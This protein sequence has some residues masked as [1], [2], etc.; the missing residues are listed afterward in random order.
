M[1]AEAVVASSYGNEAGLRMTPD[2][3]AIPPPPSPKPFLEMHTERSVSPSPR[4]LSATRTVTAMSERTDLPCGCAWMKAALA[5]VSWWQV[6]ACPRH[7][8]NMLPLDGN[9]PPEPVS[10]GPEYDP[11]WQVADE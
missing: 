3:C 10:R 2:E 1:A 5:P 9:K 4:T 6:V 8:M 11:A 7:V